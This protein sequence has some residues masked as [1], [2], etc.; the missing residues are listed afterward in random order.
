M[1]CCVETDRRLACN[2]QLSGLCGDALDTLMLGQF[3]LPPPS[4]EAEILVSRQRIIVHDRLRI[5][6]QFE[7]QAGCTVARPHVTFGC[8]LFP[9]SRTFAMH[10]PMSALG[11]SGHHGS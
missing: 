5:I 7:T 1:A 2:T 6:D 4:V 11:T 9:R 10:K 3:A 8:P